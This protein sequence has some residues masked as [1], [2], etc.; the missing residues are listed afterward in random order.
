MKLIKVTKK[1][2]IFYHD[3]HIMVIGKRNIKEKRIN[4]G[5]YFDKKNRLTVIYR[6]SSYGIVIRNKIKELLYENLKK[7]LRK[8]FAEKNKSSSKLENFLE[9]RLCFQGKF[10]KFDEND[11]RAYGGAEGDPIIAEIETDHKTVWVIIIDENG[12]EFNKYVN[13]EPKDEEN[14][15]LQ[16]PRIVA[17]TIAY[18]LTITAPFND[19]NYDA[20]ELFLQEFFLKKLC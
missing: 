8:R 16:C 17:F 12:I 15:H 2:L 10:K 6:G 5:F 13:D 3:F 11:W 9:E 14:R 4:I 19:N 18:F 7:K 20:L 1:T